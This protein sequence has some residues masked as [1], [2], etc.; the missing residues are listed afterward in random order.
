MSPLSPFG[1]RKRMMVHKSLA[2][3]GRLDLPPVFTLT[4]LREAG[5]AF[6]HATE[7]REK[8]AGRLVWARRFQLAE[9]AVVLE[10][11]EPLAEARL[12]FFAAMN[13]LADTLAVH[14][15]PE[16][17]VAFAWPD[18]VTL[19]GGVL[20]GGR[21]AWNAG[22]AEDETPDWLVFGAMLRTAG[23]SRTEPG[24]WQRGVA[25]AEEGIWDVHPAHIVEGFA[26]HLMSALYNWAEFGSA[27]EVSRWTERLHQTPGLPVSL[28]SEGNLCE[29]LGA[30]ASK[31]LLTEALAR[32]SWLDP[33]TGEPWL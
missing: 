6:R 27:H 21:L 20:G 31:R 3:A 5:D 19:D 25:L 7:L 1:L 9:F 17:P 18:M 8:T 23:H 16:K 24:T 12:A 10:P 28:D 11:A 15:P 4:S 22:C 32:P 2:N 14:C 33:Q 26:R 13:A 30:R 29:G